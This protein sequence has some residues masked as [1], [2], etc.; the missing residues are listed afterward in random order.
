MES[1]SEIFTEDKL[2]EFFEF[3]YDSCPKKLAI[4]LV[5]LSVVAYEDWRKTLKTL[6]GYDS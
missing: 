3:F 1:K 2:K 4:E 5:Y 6:H